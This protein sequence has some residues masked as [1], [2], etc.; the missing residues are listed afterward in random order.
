MFAAIFLMYE[1]IQL[2]MS[3]KKKNQNFWK[4]KKNLIPLKSIQKIDFVVI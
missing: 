2:Y 4:K 3:S 1:M